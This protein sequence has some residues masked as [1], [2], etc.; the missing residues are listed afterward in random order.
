MN[1][2]EMTTRV[3]GRVLTSVILL[4]GLTTAYIHLSLGGTIFFLNG[5]AYLVLTAGVAATALPIAFVRQL[6]WL[7]RLGFVGFALLTIGA[8]VVIG[9]YSLLGLATKIIEVAIIGVAVADL[10]NAFGS[11][12]RLARAPVAPPQ[13]GRGEGVPA[14]G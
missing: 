7:P 3:V 10:I 11:S 4:L 13:F 8:Y 5:I 1:A 14:R 9:P 2:N 6:R 12:R